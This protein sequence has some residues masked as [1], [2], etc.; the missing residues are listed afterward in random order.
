VDFIEKR[1]H[2]FI[3]KEF[4]DGD[5]ANLESS[6]SLLEAGI[7]D[8]IGLF[9]LVAFLEAAFGIRVADEDLLAEN[10]ETI[11]KIGVYVKGRSPR[12]P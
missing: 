6:S 10:F 4:L 3:I 7:I 5:S 12:Q 1:V 2:D 8:S 9:R 11:E